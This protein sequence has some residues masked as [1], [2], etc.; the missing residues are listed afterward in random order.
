MSG[1]NFLRVFLVLVRRKRLPVQGLLASL[2]SLVG[3][4]LG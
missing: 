3:H 1:M 4:K 2:E